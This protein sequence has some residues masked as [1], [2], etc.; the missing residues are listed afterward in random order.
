MSCITPLAVEK[1][2]LLQRP[3][4]TNWGRARPLIPVTSSAGQ[5]SKARCCLHLS[6]GLDRR[7]PGDAEISTELAPPNTST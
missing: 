3:C 7:M 1:R 2:S 4:W 6:F 5:I